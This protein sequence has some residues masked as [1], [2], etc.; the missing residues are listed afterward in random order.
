ME[1]KHFQ[2]LYDLIKASRTQCLNFEHF[3]SK[4]FCDKGG[5][6]YEF[7]L[8][9]EV[10]QDYIYGCCDCIG[11]KDRDE[12]W[13]MLCHDKIHTARIFCRLVAQIGSDDKI[14]YTY[15]AGQDWR[16]ET[17]LVCSILRGIN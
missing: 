16:G 2:T 9:I 15:Q 12:V 7:T 13:D 14:H 11:L 17:G 10:Q 3:L 6:W 1:T 5:K 8:P 4:Q